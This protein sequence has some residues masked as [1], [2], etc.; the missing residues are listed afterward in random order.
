MADENKN[1]TII[2]EEVKKTEEKVG[3]R[4]KE[5]KQEIKKI[6][7]DYALV[8]GRNMGMS[9][10]EGA[11]IC[12][13]IRNRNIDKAIEMVEEVLAFKRAVMMNKREC[14]HRHGKGKMAG[15]YP[16]NAA[17]EFLRMLKQLKANALHNE[18]E[19]EKCIIT[20]AKSDF[21]SRPYRRGGSRFK[22][23]NVTLKL[24]KKSKP[25]SKETKKT[26]KKK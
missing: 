19:L 6:K 24:G 22:R 4:K 7:Y 15:R 25:E 2:P 14:A 20:L 16:I 17:G 18:L 5:P 21:A 12:S 3:E 9:M 13:M 8:N 1:P 26:E 10:K 11:D 23:A